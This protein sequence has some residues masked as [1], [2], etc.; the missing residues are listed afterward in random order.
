MNRVADCILKNSAISRVLFVIDAKAQITI[1]LKTS[2]AINV[3]VA[4]QEY[5]CA[6]VLLWKVP[7]YPL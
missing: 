7:N 4:M 6:A 1:G 2:G 3:R 5:L